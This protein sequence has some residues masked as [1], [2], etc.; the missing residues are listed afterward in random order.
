MELPRER[1]RERNRERGREGGREGGINE[2]WGRCELTSYPTQVQPAD[3]TI[4][5][6]LIEQTIILFIHLT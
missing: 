3:P 6:K 2:G 1:E 4:G 5:D